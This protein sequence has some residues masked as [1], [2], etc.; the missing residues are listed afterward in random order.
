[1]EYEIR[2]EDD[3]PEY[4]QV[5]VAIDEA[6]VKKRRCVIAYLMWHSGYVYSSDKETDSKM[7]A[8][9]IDDNARLAEKRMDNLD[10]PINPQR[11]KAIS[12][13]RNQIELSDKPD[14][15]I[16]YIDVEAIGTGVILPH[17]KPNGLS[18]T[19]PPIIGSAGIDFSNYI[20]FREAYNNLHTHMVTSPKSII[21]WLQRFEMEFLNIADPRLEQRSKFHKIKPEWRFI[22]PPEY[23]HRNFEA[24]SKAGDVGRLV[25]IEGQVIEKGDVKTIM[26]HIAFRCLNKNEFGVE[27]GHI[28]LIEQDVE[29]GELTKPGSCK[30]CSGKKYIRLE[31]QETKNEAI[32]RISVQEEQVSADARSI[33]V[34][35]RGDLCETVEAG[36]SVSVVGTMRLEP[37]TKNGLICDHYILASHI[38]EKTHSMSSITLTKSDLEQVA[39]FEESVSLDEKMELI[40]QSYAGHIH[41][42]DAIKRA[43]ILAVIGSVEN[44][45]FGIRPNFHIMMIGDPGTAKTKLLEAIIETTPGSRMTDA[46]IATGPGLTAACLQREDLYTNKKRWVVEPGEIPLTP[47]GSVC[48]IDEFNLYKGDFGE[49][50]RAMESGEVNVSKV[51][52]ARIPV[53]CSIIAGANPDSKHAKRKKFDKMRPL[54]EQIDMDLTLWSRF[55]CIFVLLDEA[56]MEQDILIGQAVLKGLTVNEEGVTEVRDIPIDM[57]FI[58]KLLEVCKSREAKLSEKS[59]EYIIKQHAIKRSE[60]ISDEELRSHRQLP[61]VARLTIAAAKLDGVK[62]ATLKHV[63]FAEK[64]MASTLQEQDPG[65]VDGG[66]SKDDRETRAKVAEHFVALIEADF[67]LDD[68]TFEEIYSEMKKIWFDIPPMDF[69]DT[70]LK[71]FSRDRKTTN[72]HRSRN[73][74]YTYDGTKNPAWQVW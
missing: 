32:Q 12:S 35:L 24:L 53:Y 2:E 31:S 44:K 26:T 58:R 40:I 37:M 48:A 42:H 10:I 65:V 29:R 18:I 70:A 16:C 14:V 67:M 41:G 19:P 66:L 62:T 52:K 71:Q 45:Q 46:S 47:K 36:S 8:N 6:E 61:A 59:A 33:M 69:I 43:M 20:E 15:P 49:L 60:A 68:R 64:I 23:T 28:N 54:F 22:N 74:V 7:R 5:L 55:D 50:N 34:E 63:K 73:G 9:L 13:M 17:K 38:E 11:L 1:M 4:D 25:K 3:M 39:V 21:F 27:C 56:D 51:V 30:M 72:I 57:E